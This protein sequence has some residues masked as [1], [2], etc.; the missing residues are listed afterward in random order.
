MGIVFGKGADS[1]HP[2]PNRTI[3]SDNGPLPPIEEGKK[4][5]TG[6]TENHATH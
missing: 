5:G 3:V 6:A 2:M 4:S 1:T